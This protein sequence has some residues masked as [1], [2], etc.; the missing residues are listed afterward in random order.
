M[1]TVQIK[2]LRDNLSKYLKLVKEGEVILVKERTT[3][4]AELKHPSH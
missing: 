1:K 2:V 3:I 4:I